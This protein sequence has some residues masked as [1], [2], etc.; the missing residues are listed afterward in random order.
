MRL[1]L[2][3]SPKWPDPT[4]DRGE[5]QIEYSLYPHNGNWKEA[6]SVN[7]GYNFNYKLIP[8]LTDV[9]KGTLPAEYSFVKMNAPNLVL[10][11][12]K[13][14]EDS[15]AFIFQ[16]YESEGKDTEAE[17]EFPEAPKKVLKSNFME[18]D[19]EPLKFEG[20]K[21]KLNT[22]KNSVMTIKVYFSQK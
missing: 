16:W 3:R 17:L 20:K 14:A 13:K 11:T 5:H 1:S 8:V 10:T 12:F 19:G 15:N 18:G 22:P 4:A 7:K 6:N 9:H 2:L 21:L